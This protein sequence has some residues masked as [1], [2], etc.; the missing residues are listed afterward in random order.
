M[1][2]EGRLRFGYDLG[3]LARLGIDGQVR[4]RVGGPKYLPNGRT[5]DFAAGPQLV[6]GSGSFYGALT[7]GP[8]TEGLLTNAV[9]FTSVL[10]FGGTT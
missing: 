2:T 7:A 5:W 10:S 9:G 4:V 1:D 6:I 8:T 3:R